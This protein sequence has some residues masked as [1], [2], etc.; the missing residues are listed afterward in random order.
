MTIRWFLTLLVL[1]CCAAYGFSQNY[2]KENKTISDFIYENRYTEAQA[3]IYDLINTQKPD[4]YQQVLLMLFLS[5][6]QRLM[7]QP[8]YAADFSQKALRISFTDGARG[9]RSR[10]YIFHKIANLFYEKKV[11]D[12]AYF[13]AKKSMYY[14]EKYNREEMVIDNKMINLPIVGYYH[15]VNKNPKLAEQTFLNSI[16]LFTDNGSEC[17]TSLQYLKLSD[18][19]ISVKNLAEA[20]NYGR[21]ALKI[22]TDCNI[23]SYELSAINKLIEIYK[24]Q[25]NT[26]Q[27]YLYFTKKEQVNEDLELDEQRKILSALEVKYKT[28]ISQ[29]ENKLLKIQNAA[30]QSK[31]QI[32]IA[33]IIVSVIILAAMV[34]ITLFLKRKNYLIKQQKNELEKLNTLNQKIFSIISHDFKSPLTNLQQT[35]EL[36]ETEV[37]DLESFP[38]LATGIKQQINQTT[39]ILENLLSWAQS[40]MNDPANENAFC[41][42][43]SVARQTIGQLEMFSKQKNLQFKISIPTA[44]EVKMPA[45]ILKIVYRNLISN[46]IKYSHQNGTIELGYE[47]REDLFYVKDHGTGMNEKTL[48]RLFTNKVQS[49]QGTSAETGYGIG[50][51][52]TNELI[53]KFGGTIWAENNPEKGAIIKFTIPISA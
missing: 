26:N 29:K 42:P 24:L 3:Y 19:A 5:D 31:S 2:V 1:L 9:Q 10:G 35:I 21:K 41:F 17:E 25:N 46:A 7:G 51:H 13:Y 27:L 47:Q 34:F 52:I 16:K 38:I 12:S 49:A 44:L 48:Q 28:E 37:L 40:E 36:T 23:K 11:Y 15:L 6:I 4:K 30:E 14:A 22:A 18:V 32:F 45:E 33:I 50:L 39:L 20:E 43:E 53:C 8:Q